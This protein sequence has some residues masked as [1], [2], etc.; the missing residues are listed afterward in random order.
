M[1][2]ITIGGL[3]PSNTYDFHVLA[4]GQGGNTGFSSNRVTVNTKALPSGLSV[5]NYGATPSGGSTTYHADILI[6][7]AFVHLYIW[8]S[9]ECEFDTNPGW[10]INF[11]SDDYVCTHYIVEETTLYNILVPFLLALQMHLG[12]G[13]RLVPSLELFR[14]ECVLIQCNSRIGTLRQ[15]TAA[16]QS[17]RSH[18]L[19]L[20]FAKQAICRQ[21][22]APS[23]SQASLLLWTAEIES[24]VGSSSYYV[25][26]I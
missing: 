19:L 6:P 11:V 15:A 18:L 22:E 16:N 12:L 1:T 23:L 21:A 8:D 2:S 9:I 25:T 3:A 4:V 13:Q 24:Q 14:N 17:P 10:P 7:Y 20:T 26:K 5:T